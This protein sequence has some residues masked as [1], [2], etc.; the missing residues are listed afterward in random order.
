MK[1]PTISWSP[2]SVCARAAGVC[3]GV[4]SVV[5]AGAGEVKFDGA[6][7][8]SDALPGPT[9]LIPAGAGRQVGANLFHSFSRLDLSSGETASFQGP[10]GI[11][12]VLARVT[13]GSASSI[14]GTLRSEI[15]GA[16]L[17]LFNPAG[18]VFGPNARLDV[19]GSFAVSTA[20]YLQLADGGRFFA[21][22]G[23]A[24]VLTSAPV[25]AF[26]FLAPTPAPI[27]FTGS[28]LATPMGL[29]FTVVA[30]D[31]TLDGAAVAAPSGRL[32]L[33]SVAAVGEVPASPE[34]LA[35]T[36]AAVL[37]T[38]G[39][40]VLKNSASA[41]IDGTG[42]GRLVLRG[43]KL[44]ITGRS[45]VSSNHRGTI[46]GGPVDVRAT[47]SLTL[48]DGAITA[49]AFGTGRGGDV[50]VEAPTIRLGGVDFVSGIFA[51][52]A[53]EGVR[54]GDL[55][56]RSEDLGLTAGGT[57]STTTFGRG[58]GGN[59][60]VVATKLTV[61]REGSA[62][63][64][65][66]F[67]AVAPLAIGQGGNIHVESADA[68]ILGGGTISGDAVGRGDGGNILVE[69]T[70]L[71]IDPTFSGLFTGISSSVA[72][73]AIGNGGDITVRSDDLSL[74]LGGSIS[75][76]TFGRGN[77]GTIEVFAKKLTLT[78]AGI[79]ANF[80]FSA[81]GH[82]G[83]VF[84]QSDD[85]ALTDGA[86]I[87]AITFGRGD[88]GNV[89]I[90][91]TRFTIDGRIF[92]TGV[93][94]TVIAGAVGHGGNITVRS[95]AL[96]LTR[97]GQ[98]VASTFGQG[99][100]GSISVAAAKLTLE[101]GDPSFATGI[102]DNVEGGAVGN[103][104][105]ITVRSADLTI[106]QGAQISARTSGTGDAGSIR[107]VAD[108]A[109]LDGQGPIFNTGISVSVESQAIGKGGDII[110]K[111]GK[112]ALLS[113][114]TLSANTFG[115]GDSGSIRVR[116]DR[117]RLFSRD[118]S[119][120][121]GI[122]AAVGTGA[123]GRGGDIRVQ[124]GRLALLQG[125]A[126]IADTFG[127]GDGGDI[128]IVAPW[129]LIDQGEFNL[130]TGIVA[131][132]G[133]EAIGHGGGITVRSEQLA[134]FNGGQISSSTFG[135]GDGGSLDIAA[136]T[137]RIAQRGGDSF[138]GIFANVNFGGRGHGGDIAVRSRL[139]SIEGGGSIAAN[140]LGR[141]DGG[142]IRIDASRLFL[143]GRN[144]AAD[145]TIS[146]DVGNGAVGRGGDLI[147]RSDT[148][149][150]RGG[151]LVSTDTLGRGNGGRIQVAA[152]DVRIDGTG[153]DSFTGI[154]SDV[155]DS[156]RGH[157][158]DIELRAGTLT[159]LG[160]GEISASTFGRGDGG[161]IRISAPRLLI[162]GQSLPSFTGIS[163]DVIDNFRGHGGDI[164][165]ESRELALLGSGAITANAAGRGDGGSVQISTSS[166]QIDGQG[167]PSQ[168]TGI[169][170]DVVAGA[171]GNGGDVRV[172]ADG[173][174]L[175]GGGRISAGTAGQGNGGDVMI[176]AGTLRSD[177]AGSGVVAAVN[178]SGFGRG[179]SLEISARD[180]LLRDG[181][182]ISADTFGIGSAGSIRVQ[183]GR[184]RI[185]GPG[186]GV[187]TGISSGVGPGAIGEGGDILVKADA[188]QLLGNGLIS[189]A[190]LGGGDAGSV[191][192][193]VG[194]LLI[195]T[196]GS[197]L[198]G[199]IFAS[200][201]PGSTGSGG[202][203]DI[204]AGRVA[205]RG[206]PASTAESGIVA[207][208]ST[209]APAGSIALHLDQ[210]SLE[211]GATISSAND[212]TG[213]AGSV[214]I[215]VRDLASLRRRSSISAF[216]LAGDAGTIALASAG[217]LELHEDASITTS[218][219]RNGGGI[220]LS[221]GDYF[222][223]DRSR[224]IATAGT[225]AGSQ[226]AGAGG[227]ITVASDFTILDHGL[228]SAN[229]AIGR[230][231]NILLR[232]RFF[233]RSESLLTATGTTAGTVEIAAP[234]LDLSAGLITLPGSL[235]DTSTQLREQCAR[236]LG[237]DFS[238]LLVLG[239]NGTSLQPDEAGDV[240][241]LPR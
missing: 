109:R 8:R 162:D 95:D 9:F 128:E 30:G 46:A 214:R 141:G 138:T 178:P 120:I 108:R 62:V 105:D 239:R 208:S 163:S 197:T 88:G 181:A 49:T 67:A 27:T 97:G 52:I 143:D 160:G 222:E 28:Q 13:G 134:V 211:D 78:T 189:A 11:G 200:V 103:G 90:D 168:F 236:R 190:T 194:E 45:L 118:P 230:G 137:L 65:G 159:V 199:G 17:Y 149:E 21:R 232:A 53:A 207:R 182:E 10:A 147:L 177:G 87:S 220:E 192:L 102:F 50:A 42:G 218:A 131:D 56:V 69:A 146:S 31:L 154:S 132:V 99:N 93:Y 173:L 126:I 37:P 133:S 19:S 235:L 16:N 4:W 219:G 60:H 179:G 213:D 85:L 26:G 215:A 2:R 36:R 188:V 223:L 41:A 84:V 111:G 234:D 43:G 29:D 15:P 193:R 216:S 203:V 83:D 61:D 20:D 35:A 115:T 125:S 121:T 184:L 63:S 237:L 76:N 119:R 139:L 127:R 44:E 77:G 180:L 101:A 59:V 210:L 110:L 25:S 3:A 91:A 172:R 32:S 51:S 212:A 94:A 86:G 187:L 114:A 233:F 75:A 171:F 64:T 217:R 165:I 104:G 113:G 167:I 158:G 174:T 55:D 227:N 196:A 156:G 170:S 206:N 79:S 195:D 151:A 47:E 241:N 224:I 98:I 6:Y 1:R 136:G 161:T 40:V 124:A 92:Q 221:A 144:L 226:P 23:E 71:R 183:A 14:D 80:G 166:L 18:V 12:N 82:G 164:V 185:E 238:S 150:I 5:S 201:E 112:I 66:I 240:V 229:A 191:R 74:Q 81:V 68:A 129:I 186:A 7:G 73:D 123:V 205:L 72:Q 142:T 34:A 70:R 155:G 89:T 231:G 176:T 106:Q 122:I 135:Q 38:M 140:A 175:T 209:G 107:V 145:T 225:V 130:T 96:S 117:L 228:I 58:D 57:I 148:I 202:S 169:A 24:D 39:A 33:V 153:A 48:S 22:L 152:R 116:A 100:G 204:A 157:G 198:R 54:G